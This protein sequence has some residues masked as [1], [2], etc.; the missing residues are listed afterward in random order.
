M[1][2]E[3]VSSRLKALGYCRVSTE[4][5][6]REGLSLEAQESKIHA[7]STIKDFD[8]LEIIVDPGLSGK[9]M[10]RAGLQKALT[11]LRSG[12]ARALIV[13]KLDRLTRSTKDLLALVYDTFIPESISLHSITE[14]LDTTSANGRFFL[15][16]LGAMAN[17]EAETIRERTKEA[18]RHKIAK[19]EWTGRVPFGFAVGPNGILTGDPTQQ[20]I[21]R[22]AKRL[23]REGLSIRDIARRVDLPSSTVHKMITTD[24][25]TLK[26]C[27]Q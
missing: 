22:K 17:W 25:R 16:M 26:A 3:S 13:Y 6:A 9:D 7:Y 10:Q 18:L 14:T 2:K 1:Q 4:D 8:L 23:R 27:Y 19:G 5:Q 15:T 24:F 20:A 21:I 11:L 12:E